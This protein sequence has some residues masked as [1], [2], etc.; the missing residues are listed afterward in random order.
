MI[1]ASMR[2][3][4]PAVTSACTRDCSK[5]RANEDE[6]AGVIAHEIAHVTQRHI[7]RRVHANSRQGILTTAMMLGAIII[8]A[9]GG[10]SEATEA[11]IAVAQGAA[12]Q[13]NINFTRANEYEADR[14][15]IAALA[16]AGFD[17]YGMASFLRGHVAPDNNEPGRCAHLNSC[18]R[19]R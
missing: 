13:Q 10:G 5:P 11:A 16:G 8:A 15:G 6:L 14:V 19:T 7:A 3:P 12:A 9:A 17:P 2:S 18:A 4:C 1:P